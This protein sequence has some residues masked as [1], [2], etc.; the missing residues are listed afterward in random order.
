MP[1]FDTEKADKQSRRIAQ[2][3]FW[4]VFVLLV[5]LASFGTWATFAKEDFGVFPPVFLGIMSVVLWIG[6]IGLAI[7]AYRGNEQR[8]RVMREE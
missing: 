8:K 4:V 5:A 1:D 6:I 2:A 7:K 3:I